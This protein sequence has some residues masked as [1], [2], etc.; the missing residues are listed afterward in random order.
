MKTSKSILMIAILAAGFV[1]C[2]E[3]DLPQPIGSGI[4]TIPNSV[5]PVD[6]EFN[7]FRASFKEDA[8]NNE[9][10]TKTEDKDQ[11][12]EP[13]VDDPDSWNSKDNNG[14]G[15]PKGILN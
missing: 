4:S 13:H 8:A 2:Q 15:L 12:P 5:D 10:S 6:A 9:A 3:E 7:E 14:G 1:A 11:F